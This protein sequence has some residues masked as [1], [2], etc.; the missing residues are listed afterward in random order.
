MKIISRPTYT[1]KI[2]SFL[3]KGMIIALTGQRRVGKSYILQDMVRIIGEK[4]PESNIVYINKEKKLFSDIR[5]DADLS[6][7]LSD[8]IIEGRQ[9]YLL[10][11]EVQD[12]AGFEDTL[13][14]LNA[15]EECQI[16]VTGS[17]A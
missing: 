15:D 7:Y 13:R 14:S 8:K 6:N 9:N 2:E 1:Q 16:I 4:Y 12:I 5:N 10:I 3:N 11:D 17:N